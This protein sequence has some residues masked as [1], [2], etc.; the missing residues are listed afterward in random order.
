MELHEI[1]PREIDEFELLI[2]FVGN[3]STNQL[4]LV[5]YP[6]FNSASLDDATI[7][8]I[9][10]QFRSGLKLQFSIYTQHDAASGPVS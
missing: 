8:D 2:V 3:V 1:K 9:V 6:T 5:F 4:K 10:Q 7:E